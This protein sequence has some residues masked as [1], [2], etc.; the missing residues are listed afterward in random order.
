MSSDPT[1]DDSTAPTDDPRP[2]GL[3]SADSLVIV[4]TGNG[5]GKSS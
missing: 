5:K 1:G 2:D 3:R 4:N